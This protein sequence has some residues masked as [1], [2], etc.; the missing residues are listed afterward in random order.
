MY[1]IVCQQSIRDTGRPLLRIHLYFND[2][3]LRNEIV[4]VN[5]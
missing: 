3:L 4:K 1:A 2:L 5:K